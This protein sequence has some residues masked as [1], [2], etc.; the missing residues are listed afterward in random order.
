[1][2][3]QIENTE[4][5][6]KQHVPEPVTSIPQT[7]IKISRKET[8]NPLVIKEAVMREPLVEDLIMAERISAKVDGVE[9]TA[10]LLSQITIFDGASLPPEGLRRL[11]SKD[12]LDLS[13]EL[14]SLGVTMSQI[15]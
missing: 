11:S 9:F 2:E 13:R 6:E 12:F 4:E 3:N 1:M 15:G 7:K 5:L 10:A 8:E 14:D